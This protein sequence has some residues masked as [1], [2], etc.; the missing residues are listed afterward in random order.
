MSLCTLP[1]ISHS[2]AKETLSPAKVSVPAG[3]GER[4]M[5]V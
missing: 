5:G 1:L 3:C 4:H 2:F